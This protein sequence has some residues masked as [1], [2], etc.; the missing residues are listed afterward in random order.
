MRRMEEGLQSQRGGD[1]RAGDNAE[2]RMDRSKSE[3]RNA[4]TLQSCS[5]SSLLP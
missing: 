3:D 2:E 5:L 4:I 1:W